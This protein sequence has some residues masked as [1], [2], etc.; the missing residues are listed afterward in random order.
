VIVSGG[1]GDGTAA[2]CG[3]R[4]IGGETIAQLP[5]TAGQPDTPGSAIAS[6][7]IEF[8]LSPENIAAKLIELAHAS[9]RLKGRRRH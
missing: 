8:A 9:D 7:C 6:G 2:L 4:D 1:D 5:A 3:I